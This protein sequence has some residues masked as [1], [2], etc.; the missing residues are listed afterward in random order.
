MTLT[1]FR[2]QSM[3][4]FGRAQ[5][6]TTIGQLL[7]E[8]RTVNNRFQDISI[9]LPRELNL[10]ESA[11]RNLVKAEIPRGKI[12][13]RIRYTP[14]E[15]QQPKVRINAALAKEYVEQ[16]RQLKD[17]GLATELPVQVLTSMPGVME[18]T[19]AEMDEQ[20]A[21]AAVEGV[22]RAAI[23]ALRAERAREG[24]A[25]GV[26]LYELGA[27]LGILV[28]KVEANQAEVI[29]R[30]RERLLQRVAELE[31]EIK[32]KLDP[33]RLEMEVALFVDRSDVSEE[34]VRLRA[35]IERLNALLLNEHKEPAGK[36]LDFLTQELGREV[37]TI[38]SKVRDTTLTG[39]ALEMKS[40]VERI[41]E[42]V[43]NIQ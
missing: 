21:W 14:T 9:A 11:L 2:I 28:G 29:A 23:E 6:E 37:N 24:Q 1:S 32:T 36:N 10:F 4:G 20:Q 27:Q 22:M 30:Y 40:I 5:A 33:G 25:L 3:T 42:Q 13:C 17:L 16:L 26:Q 39:L 35:H 18:I 12:D 34:V 19:P 15:A 43:Q 7:V 31:N 38:G 41:R 8:L